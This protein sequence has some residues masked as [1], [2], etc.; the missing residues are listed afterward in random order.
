MRRWL[1][2]AGLLL[3]AAPSAAAS[4]LPSVSSGKLPGPPLLYAKA[5]RVPQLE[6]RAPFRARPLLVSGTDAYRG[7]E[8]LYQDYLFDDHGADT[9]ANVSPPGVSGFS[10]ASGDLLYPSPSRY[11]NN[12]ADLVELRIKP[13]A[14]AIVYRVTLGAVLSDDAAVVGIGIDTDRSGGAPVAW[15]GGAGLSSP[16]LDRFITAWGTGGRVTDLPGGGAQALPAGAVTISKRTNQMTIRVPRALMN[17]GRA[18]WRYVAGTGVRS[19]TGFERVAPGAPGVYNL[20]FRFDEGQPRGIGVWFEADQAK[21]LAGATSGRFHADVSFA[22]LAGGAECLDPRAGAQAGAHLPVAAEAPRGRAPRLPRVRRPPAA[23]PRV[24]AEDV[25]PHAP[26]RRHVG[27]A[28]AVGDLHPVRGVLAPP[29]SSSSATTRGAS[30]SRRSAAGRTAGTPTR[31]RSTSS[32]SGPTSRGTSGSTPRAWRS[33]ATRWAA[34]A[35]TSSGCSGPT[36]SAPR[37]RRSGRRWRPGTSTPASC[38]RTRAG[39]PT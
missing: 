3:L 9:G 31:P 36:C 21:A 10:P 17:P 24:R 14:K 39:C 13:T 2:A 23:L 32:R 1:L 33:A 12:A 22:R 4:S 5:P 11:A 19:G 34:T 37:S 28:L 38:S 16:G 25:S 29:A 15:P 20:A 35:P 6:N 27:A 18:T 8:Y 30:T 7:G 26:G